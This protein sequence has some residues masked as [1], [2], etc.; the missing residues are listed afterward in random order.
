MGFSEQLS[1][2]WQNPSSAYRS[3]PF[4]SWNDRLIPDRLCRQIEGMKQAGMGGFFM[5]SRYGLKTPYL[6]EE[7]FACVSAC[8]EKARQLDMKACLYDEDRWPSGTSGGAVTRTHPEFREH[9]LA[10]VR[11]EHVRDPGNVVAMFAVRK[12]ATGNCA[13]YEP[14]KDASAVPAGQEACAF[15]IRRRPDNPWYNDGAYLDTM[16]PQ[17]VAEYIRVNHEQYA[18]RYGKDFGSLVPGIFTDEPHYGYSWKTGE[19]ELANVVWTPAMVQEFRRRR[20]YDIRNHLPELMMPLAAGRFS[21]ARMDFYRTATELFVESYTGQIGAWCGRCGIAMTGH[22][23]LEG[24]LHDQ[25]SAAGACM[26]HYEHMQW[27]GMDLLC[28]QANELLTAKQVCSVADQLGKQRVL[29]EMYGCTGWDWPLEGHKFITDW[30]YACGVNLCCP[31]LTH[32]SLLGGGK[33]DYPASIYEHSPWWKYYSTVSDY[34]ARLGVMLTQGRPVRDVLVIHPIDSAWGLYLF[35]RD[36]C[37]EFDKELQQL[38]YALSGE[39]YDWDFADESLLG[40]YG[41]VARG[42]LKLGKMSYKVVVVPPSHTLRKRTVALLRRFQAHGGQVLIVGQKPTMVDGVPSDAAAELAAQA[43]SC[44]N[45]AEE[46]AA[47]LEAILPRRVSITEDGKEFRQAWIMLRAVEGGQLLFVQSHDRKAGHRLRCR[48]AG[49][50]PVVTWDPLTG[51]RTRLKAAKADG[52]VEFDL[53]LPPTGSALLSLAV[54]CPGA[55]MPAKAPRVVASKTFAGPFDIELAEPNTFPLDY[56][57]YR[58]GEGEFS[59][60]VPVLKADELIRAHFGLGV[61]HN[62]GQ[63]PWYLYATGVIDTSPRGPVQMRWTFHVTDSPERCA[64]AV[65]RPEGLSIT[66]NGKPVGRP[67]GFWVDPD[68]RTIDI[69]PLLRAGENEILLSF[70]YRPDMELEDMYLAGRFGVS[71]RDGQAPSPGNMTLVRPPREL[72]LGSWLGQGLDFYGG[73]VFHNLTIERPRRGR[74]RINLPEA[75]CTAAAIHVNGKTYVLPWAPFSADITDAL[76]DGANTVRVEVIGGRKNILGPLHTPR[77]TWT[78]PEQFSP[79]AKDWT[80][81]YQLYDHGLMSQVV[82]DT[83]K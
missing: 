13:S 7:W 21:K 25:I 19:N 20:R 33:R 64:L 39:H 45:S 27:P 83:V 17:A 49:R 69:T 8:I 74:V 18:R 77:Q 23:L 78:G 57:Q 30:Q 43:R 26:P 34:V 66:V 67:E 35:N 56:C 79:N 5:H 29:S 52:H 50:G 44:P 24:K 75:A 65:E 61:R 6:S 38:I 15:E 76:V 11:P 58:I 71:R 48:V 1:A 28:D 82:V 4:W 32:Y 80:F 72:T 62:G 60:P 81:E 54:R 53:D 36:E 46:I 63:Q 73:A 16:N 41:K 2:E 42:N 9:Y 31:H 68:I 55:A 22:E 10:M 47:A 37:R 59:Q 70:T 40:K 51:Q 12:D 14:L 3:A